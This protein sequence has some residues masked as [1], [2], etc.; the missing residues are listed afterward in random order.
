MRKIQG[1]ISLLTVVSDRFRSPLITSVI[2]TFLVLGLPG[3]I[4]LQ[5]AVELLSAGRQ[6][7]NVCPH[8]MTPVST[9]INVQTKTDGNMVK[10]SDRHRTHKYSL[11]SYVLFSWTSK[12]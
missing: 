5:T 2:V 6:Q 12:M 7:L 4:D 1:I 10:Y 8:N 9:Q 11:P 3:V